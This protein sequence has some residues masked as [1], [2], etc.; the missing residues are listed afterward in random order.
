MANI[1]RVPLFGHLRADPNRHVIYWDKGRMKKSGKGLAF[2]FRPLS[3]SISELPCDDREL[4]FSFH[5]RSL[6]YQDVMAQ[7][8]ITWRVAAPERLADRLDFSIDLRRGRWNE[9]P[10]EQLAEILTSRAQ[11]FAWGYLAGHTVREILTDGVEVL[12]ERIGAGLL[13]S[14]AL[15]A[16]GLAVVDVAVSQVAPT[17]ELEKALQTPAM[18]AIQQEA[19]EATFQRRAMAV[20]KER[21][22]QE[23]ELQNQIELATRESDLIGQRGQNEQR[24]AREEAAA[25]RIALEASTEATRMEASARAES[26]ETI[27]S[28]RVEAE[29]ERMHIYRGLEPHVLMGLAAREFAGKL[30]NIEHLNLAP[31]RLGTILGDL[32]EAGAR[33]LEGSRG[34]SAKG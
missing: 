26:I 22:I 34:E 24:R 4:P 17:S 32:M 11:Q 15:D 21:A 25:G 10:L 20:E 2:W 9:T 16:M 19:D 31:D 28:A 5:G 27:E 14:E 23:N 3:A 18:E 30:Q 12:R 7:G 29:K 33:F 6:D 8:V 1:T 13:E